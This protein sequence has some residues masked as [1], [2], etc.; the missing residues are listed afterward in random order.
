MNKP[1]DDKHVEAKRL[2]DSM[3]NRV[4]G[5]E[6][7]RALGQ[8]IDLNEVDTQCSEIIRYCEIINEDSV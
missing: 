5:I 7:K 2:I 4:V 3:R 6:R 1:N 8:S